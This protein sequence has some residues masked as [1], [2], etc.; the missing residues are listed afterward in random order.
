M[1]K[2][3]FSREF[4]LEVLKQLEGGVPIEQL[5]RDVGTRP[6]LIRTWQKQLAGAPREAFPGHGRRPDSEAELE[7]LRKENARLKAERD[8]LKKAVG[9]FAKEP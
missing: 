4:K 9:F 3:F 2:R 7:R 5:A 8:I 1:A 6:Q